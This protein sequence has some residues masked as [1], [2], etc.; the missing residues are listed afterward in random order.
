VTDAAT[1]FSECWFAELLEDV[2]L[3]TLKLRVEEDAAVGN[4]LNDSRAL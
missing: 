2:L 4:G 1:H 3:W